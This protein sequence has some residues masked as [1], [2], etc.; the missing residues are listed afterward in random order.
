VVLHRDTA[1]VVGD[2]HVP[3]GAEVHFDAGGVAGDG[4]VHR[5]VDD[6]GEEVVEGI[7]VGTADVHAGAAADGLEPFEDFDVGRG[8]RTGLC[9]RGLFGGGAR[10][11]DAGE[12]VGGGFGRHAALTRIVTLLL[13]QP[14]KVAAP[15]TVRCRGVTPP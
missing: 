6:L 11:G 7:A 8:I 9:R 15:F 4:L 10:F 2:G 14:R 3:V 12:E 1:A 5:V 13:A